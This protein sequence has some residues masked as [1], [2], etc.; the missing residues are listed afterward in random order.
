MPKRA[1]VTTVRQLAPLALT[2]MTTKSRVTYK[3]GVDRLVGALGDREL[4]RINLVELESIRDAVRTKVGKERVRDALRQHRRLPSYD[5]DAYGTGA[6]ENFVRA[7]RF[8]FRYAVKTKNLVGENPAADLR[9][10]T[11]PPVLRR[12]LTTDELEQIWHVATTTGDDPELDRRLLTFIRHTAARREGCLNLSLDHLDVA[13]GT[14]TLAEKRGHVRVLPLQ[15]AFA[16]D[17]VGFANSRGARQPGDRVFRHANG[18]D[19]SRARFVMIFNRVDRHLGW[20]EPLKVGPHW[21]RHTT[22]ADILAVSDVRVS[23]A[24][25]GH[26]PASLG[27]IGLYTRPTPDDLR[28]AYDAVFDSDCT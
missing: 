14:V 18:R 22:L 11:R 1:R 2:A 6:A 27:T 25:A 24:Y 13:R 10:P 7:T 17:L 23:E 20:T 19:I 4:D 5:P 16:E 26:S 9:A 12:P 3:P 28:A 21:I 8:L 15:P